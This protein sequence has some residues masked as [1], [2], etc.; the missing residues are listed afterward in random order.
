[1]S[2]VGSLDFAWFAAPARLSLSGGTVHVWRVSL[3]ESPSQVALLQNIL[4]DDERSRAGRFYFRRD[5]ERFVVGRGVLRTLLGRYLDR[6]PESLSFTYSPHGKPTLASEFG[7]DAIRFNLSHSQGTALYAFT[8]NRELGVDLEFIRCDLET[9]QIAQRFFSQSEIAALLA[10]PLSLRKYAFF[11]CWTR[12]E[13][14]IKA[15]GEGLSMPLDQFD[16]SLIPEEPAVLLSTRPDPDE[17]RGWSLRNLTPGAG[18]AAAL[19]V[20]G[21]DWDLSCWQWPR[22]GLSTNRAPAR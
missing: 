20:K 14:Y 7:D 21:H 6:S 10:L 13:A 4:D 1:M 17:G 16:V 22:S 8:R 11:L 19:A 9:E 2:P 3:D 12:K 15:R 18:Y 5:R